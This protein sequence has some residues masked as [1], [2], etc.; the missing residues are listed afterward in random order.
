MTTRNTLRAAHVAAAEAEW[1]RAVKDALR[2][3]HY[4]N[5]KGQ[6][7]APIRQ[8]AVRL[9]TISDA[10][11]FS[12]FG[13]PSDG[14]NE[15][16]SFQNNS[17]PLSVC[18]LLEFMAHFIGYQILDDGDPSL[19]YLR[20]DLMDGHVVCESG[21]EDA[22]PYFHQNRELLQAR[23]PDAPPLTVELALQILNDYEADR[24]KVVTYMLV[25]IEQHGADCI[26]DEDDIEAYRPTPFQKTMIALATELLRED[27]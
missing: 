5:R 26:W 3:I 22:K 24:E 4:P 19:D 15:L 21:H 20:Y 8:L 18:S 9:L 16:V 14:I 23:R 1:E 25:D 2:Y 12:V 13:G 10:T 6:D 11:R 7:N 17:S 27:T